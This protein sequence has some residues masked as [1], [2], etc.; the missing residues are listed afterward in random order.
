[1]TPKAHQEQPKS[2]SGIIRVRGARTNNLR[3]VDVNIPK[4]QLTVVTGVS[5]SGKSSLTFDTSA[6][7][8][9]RLL[10]GGSADV[11]QSVEARGREDAVDCRRCDTEPGGELYWPFPQP[12][13]HSRAA[14]RHRL[15]CLDRRRLRSRSS[16]VHRLTGEVAVDPALRGGP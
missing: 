5:G 9:Q 4:K 2:V 8:S 13:S 12:H 11:G 15:R 10:A 14:L 3:N 1:M 6:A 16:V 7:E